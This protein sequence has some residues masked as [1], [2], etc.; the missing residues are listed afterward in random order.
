MF[1]NLP[2]IRI[3]VEDLGELRKQVGKLRDHYQLTGMN[4]AEFEM[5]VKLLKRP[6]KENVILYSTTHDNDTLEGYY[7]DLEANKKIALRR[8]FHNCGYD[9]RTFHE[10]VIRYC[11]DSKADITIIP[12]WDILGLKKEGRMNTPGTIGSPNWEWKVKNLKEFYAL[13]PQIGEWIT[14]S[15]RT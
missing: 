1:E 11:M 5:E 7:L 10:L 3:V 6:R 9:N 15:N 2:T 14:A 13:L 8:F 12:A 4:V